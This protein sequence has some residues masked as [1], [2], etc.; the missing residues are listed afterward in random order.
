MPEPTALSNRVSVN[1]QQRLFCV[2]P[3]GGKNI[4]AWEKVMLFEW[5]GVV[6]CRREVN[7]EGLIPLPTPQGVWVVLFSS[8]GIMLWLG[9]YSTMRIRPL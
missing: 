5:A 3:Q 6:V 9:K 8:C 1:T 7:T 2:P 4:R